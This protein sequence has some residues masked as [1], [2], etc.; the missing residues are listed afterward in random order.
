MP[1]GSIWQLQQKSDGIVYEGYTGDYVV[2][3][4]YQGGVNYKDELY[5]FRCSDQK[6]CC[7]RECCDPVEAGIPWWLILILVLIALLLLA[8]CLGIAYYI[9]KLCKQR[10]RPKPK[11]QPKPQ[12]PPKPKFKGD[13]MQITNI[14]EAEASK[15][16]FHNANEISAEQLPL[17]AYYEKPKPERPRIM[18]YRENVDEVAA[19]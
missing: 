9:W 14:P 11:P 8:L 5:I 13:P 2:C 12:P 19:Y 1:A 4:F 15:V 10:P 17:I 16:E 18:Y 3:Q 7:G 6:E